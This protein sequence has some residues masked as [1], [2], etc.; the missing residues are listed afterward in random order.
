M[1]S[2][3]EI[4]LGG[5]ENGVQHQGQRQSS[6]GSLPSECHCFGR[7]WRGRK[8]FTSHSHFLHRWSELCFTGGKWESFG[9][10]INGT[11]PYIRSLHLCF[12]TYC[13][14][15]IKHRAS[16]LGA[17]LWKLNE[18]CFPLQVCVGVCWCERK[19][20]NNSYIAYLVAPIPLFCPSQQKQIKTAILCTVQMEANFYSSQFLTV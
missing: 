9:A 19:R 4:A 18:G 2:T 15:S 12:Y 16:L 1:Q 13:L 17:V 6:A 5:K 8:I 20:I 7:G 11:W 14:F 3:S 10:S